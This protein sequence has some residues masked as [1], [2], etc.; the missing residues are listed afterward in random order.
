MIEQPGARLAGRHGT[1]V[2][3]DVLHE[4][5]VVEQVHAGVV[6]AVAPH[7]PSVVA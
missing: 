3:A 6:G 2:V 5:E 7:S 1:A 4:R